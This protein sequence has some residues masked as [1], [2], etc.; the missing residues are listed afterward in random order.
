MSTGCRDY[1]MTRRALMAAG[2]AS[3]LGMNVHQLLAMSGKSHAA[4]CEHVILFWNGGGMSHID[5][6]DPKPGR[7]TGGELAPI[8]TSVSGIEISEA[9]PK[10]A[11]Q[12]KHATLIRSIAG[13]QGDHGRAS[14]NL[15]TSY[16]PGPNLVHPGMGSV[17][18]HELPPLGDLPAYISI[19]GMAPRAGYLGQKCEAYFVPSPGDKDPYLAFPEGIVNERGNKRLETLA[20]FNA[21]FNG[22]STDERLSSAQTSIDDAVR[23]MRSPAL[24][25][26]ELGKVPKETIDRYGNTPFGRGA[27]LAKRLVEKGV[28]FVQINRGGF[29]THSNNFPAMRDHGEVMDPG[30]GSLIEDLAASGML[31]KTM[32]IMLSEF[33]RTPRINKDAGRDHW[34]NVFSCFMAGGGIR[35]GQVIGS[36]DEDGAEPK[37]RPVKVQDLHASICH[38]L[39]I[40][41]DKEVMTPLERPMRLVDQGK[42]IDELFA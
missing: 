38:A 40:D 29:D 7:P 18:A 2:G 25:A 36:S 34:A 21:R 12:M 27:L 4:K 1:H 17:A 13:T 5:T 28:R 35:G 42:K 33:G 20:K 9:F 24:E 10:V 37:D 16:L 30:L 32:V 6:W 41:P 19:S 11:S 3:L 22:S 39:G 23:L 15:Q 31:E 26:F 14:Y 8:K